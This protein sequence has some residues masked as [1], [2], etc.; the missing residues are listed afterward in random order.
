MDE[1]TLKLETVDHQTTALHMQDFHARTWLVD[2]DESITVL[3]VAV[4]L[5]RDYAAERVEAL[6]HVGWMRIQEEPVCVIEA[7]HPLSSKNN[8]LPE[9]LRVDVARESDLHTVRI[10]N[11]ADRL[12]ATGI[13][14][15]E[16]VTSQNGHLAAS[17]VDTDREKLSSPLGHLHPDLCLPVIKPAF[18]N[19]FVGTELPNSLAALQKLLV[20]GPEI[21]NLPHNFFGSKIS[22]KLAGRNQAGNT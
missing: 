6:A 4:H 8:E 15:T 20:D 16:P 18:F 9:C 14:A 1:P 5:V 13:A 19:A 21:I 22:T 17:V 12:D 11:L 3:D 10:D 7:E 2:E